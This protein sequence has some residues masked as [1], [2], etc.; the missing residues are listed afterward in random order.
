MA[1][2]L[3]G[4][5]FP[6]LRCAIL[7]TRG[8][9]MKT[10]FELLDAVIQPDAFPSEEARTIARATITQLLHENRLLRSADNIP[11]DPSESPLLLGNLYIDHGELAWSALIDLASIV[12]ALADGGPITYPAI[13]L[14]SL[15]LARAV[16]KNAKKLTP[17]ELSVFSWLSKH[18]GLQ[19]RAKVIKS[20]SCNPTQAALAIR[21]LEGAGLIQTDPTGGVSLLPAK[22]IGQ[23]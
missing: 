23:Q 6:L 4:S 17:P 14:A 13:G 12:L 21:S 1:A 22:L 16:W 2:L 18:P 20:V 9:V 19:R 7:N 15:D 10:L 3:L 11:V 5:V 8:K